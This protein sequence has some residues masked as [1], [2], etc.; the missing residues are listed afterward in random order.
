[1]PAPNASKKRK[2]ADSDISDD[3][4]RAKRRKVASQKS[5]QLKPQPA[6]SPQQPPDATTVGKRKEAAAQDPSTSKPEL[7]ARPP[8]PRINKLAPQRPFPTVPTSVSATGPRSAHQEGKNFICVTRKTKLGSYL[9][10]CKDIIIKDGYN[11]YLCR[12]QAR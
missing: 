8:R 6:E 12:F 10:R 9:R 7:K 3:S 1:M 4:S 11:V 5:S 2:S